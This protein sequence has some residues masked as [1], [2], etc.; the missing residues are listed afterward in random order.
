MILPKIKKIKV[1]V[2]VIIML[3]IS[4]GYSQSCP[5]ADTTVISPPQNIWNIPV[6]NNWDGL[7]VI[8]WNIQEF[9]QSGNTVNYVNEII[10]DLLPDIIGI[11]EITDI[12]QFEYLSTQIPAYEFIHTN[13]N[14]D[15]GLDL[16]FITRRD[17][18]EILN[19]STLFPSDGWEFAGRYPLKAEILWGCG[20][21][22]INLTVINVHFKAYDD[23]FEQRFGASGILSNYILTHPNDNIVVIG[24]F[25]DEITDPESNNSLWPLVSDPNAEFVT[26]VIANNSYQNSYPWGS[27]A[28]FIDHILISSN[29][30]DENENGFTQTQRIDDYVGSSNYQNQISDHRPVMW[31]IPIA[32]ITVPSGLVINEIMNNPASVSDSYGEWIEIVNIS[33]ETFDLNGLVLKDNDSDSHTISK[34]GG[35]IVNPGAFIV[36]GVNDDFQLNGG[37]ELD[38]QFSNFYL[39]NALDEVIISHPNGTVIDEVWYDNGVTFPDPSGASMSLDNPNTDNNIGS[40]W[41]ISTTPM[42]GGDFG[43]PGESN[44]CSANGDVNSDGITDILDIVLIVDYILGE[45]SF[46]ETQICCSDQNLDDSI[47][48]VDV[49]ITIDEDM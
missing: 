10:S 46:T 14:N 18:I 29:L 36:L 11:Q 43:S 40:N 42:Y 30:F 3:I 24:D 8:T 48:I 49:I 20:E 21:S 27:Y 34:P 9:P 15:W 5:P 22:T 4:V 23:G 26:M 45:V 47:N 12:S 7:E 17:C 37:V 32:E 35:L 16:G 28:G 2:A 1:M 25:N 6:V 44:T 31:K 13:Y 19:Y 39:S 41:S 33:N 38:Y